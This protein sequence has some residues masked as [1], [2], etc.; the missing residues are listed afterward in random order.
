MVRKAAFGE[1]LD[2]LF[3]VVVFSFLKTHFEANPSEPRGLEN[4]ILFGGLASTL[5]KLYSQ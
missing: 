4:G 2:F 1:L 5:K 3:E